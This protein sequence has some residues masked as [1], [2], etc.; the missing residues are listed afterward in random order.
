VFE[1]DGERVEDPAG[2][3]CALGEAVNGPGGYF[4][5]DPDSLR[6]C[7]RG[8]FGAQP[9]FE[10]RWTAAD[11]AR[12]RLASAIMPPPA[13]RADAPM[14]HRSAA[15]DVIRVLREARVRILFE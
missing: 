4:G 5:A 14:P 15:D 13:L 6:D 11:A 1:L 10:L 8:G 9:P 3:Y 12:S 2:L 7:L